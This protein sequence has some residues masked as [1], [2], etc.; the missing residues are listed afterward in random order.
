MK[1]CT[2]IYTWTCLFTKLHGVTPH[3]TVIFKFTD[4]R[5]SERALKNFHQ[6]ATN[7]IYFIKKYIPSALLNYD[8]SLNPAFYQRFKS[9]FDINVI[10]AC[11]FQVRSLLG[12]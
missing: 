3:K 9:V 6:S 7:R 12:W 10:E 11:T 4:V 8:W 1:P 5:T 2:T